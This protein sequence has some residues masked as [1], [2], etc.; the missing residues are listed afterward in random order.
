MSDSMKKYY[1]GVAKKILNLTK[2]ENF[3]NYTQGEISNVYEN[4]GDAYK[5]SGK[6]WLANDSY[7]RASGYAYDGKIK[8]RLRDKR[9]G[10]YDFSKVKVQV[11]KM[12]SLE[13]KTKTIPN[14]KNKKKK[15]FEP[16]FWDR[17][18][19]P[20]TPWA[21]LSIASFLLALFFVSTNLTGY[22]TSIASVSDSKWLG[23]CFFACG[24][25]FTFV[26]LNSKKRF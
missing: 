1:E 24:L 13:S 8:E 11:P 6:D 26:F 14:L 22:A 19:K 18:L 21:I 3:E 23:F 15:L 10:N 25:V 2:D 9:T 20:N 7:K 5:L 16:G 17:T 4:L 12:N